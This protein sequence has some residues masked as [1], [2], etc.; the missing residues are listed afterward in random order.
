[1]TDNRE[2]LSGY[3]FTVKGHAFKIDDAFKQRAVP[4]FLTAK[5]ATSISWKDRARSHGGA[6][7]SQDI[8]VEAEQKTPDIDEARFLFVG[9]FPRSIDENAL[10]KGVARGGTVGETLPQ[11]VLQPVPDQPSFRVV[12]PQTYTPTVG[13]LKYFVL[14]GVDHNTGLWYPYPIAQD[15]IFYLPEYR[16]QS[17][18]LVDRRKDWSH[19]VATASVVDPSKPD[20]TI[21][22]R[23]Y[24]GSQADNE[25]A[26]LHLELAKIGL[27]NDRTSIDA[28]EDL[29]ARKDGAKLEL[30]WLLQLFLTIGGKFD[31]GHAESLDIE[32]KRQWPQLAWVISA[33]RLLLLNK[34]ITDGKLKVDFRHAYVFLAYGCTKLAHG[35]TD[36]KQIAVD[37]LLFAETLVPDRQDFNFAIPEQCKA[38]STVIFVA[39]LTKIKPI[40]AAMIEGTKALE[41]Q[42][43]KYTLRLTPQAIYDQLMQ[44]RE[45]DAVR[46]LVDQ[47]VALR[48]TEY[49]NQ[50]EQYCTSLK[51]IIEYTEEV[52]A[53]L[54]A[55]R[56]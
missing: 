21:Q 31:N 18:T 39:F 30:K 36:S 56:N 51:S 23:T 37:A 2:D 26:R 44:S 17:R 40:Y 13:G 29:M 11:N 33:E 15:L 5:K 49:S 46:L 19:K 16:F 24:F 43:G 54:E 55:K 45:Q 7:T 47:L 34:E 25:I 52:V 20:I 8:N 6:S 12:T 27:D 42:H 41:T 48:A 9:L 28:I 32:T 22:H 4:Q 14:M 3:A 1:M 53:A 38:L 10:S 35:T 50:L